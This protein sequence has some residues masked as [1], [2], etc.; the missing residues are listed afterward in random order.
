MKRVGKGPA[1]DVVGAFPDNEGGGAVIRVGQ[2][3]TEENA[4]DLAQMPAAVGALRQQAVDM[5]RIAPLAVSEPGLAF[6]FHRSRVTGIANGDLHR[7]PSPSLRATW[8]PGNDRPPRPPAWSGRQRRRRHPSPEASR[9]QTMFRHNAAIARLPDP[10]QLCAR[11]AD[12]AFAQV[13][14]RSSRS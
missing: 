10:P 11:P 14:M 2:G 6:A 3:D 9:R 12:T 8:R 7:D 13:R 5:G 4:V 1:H